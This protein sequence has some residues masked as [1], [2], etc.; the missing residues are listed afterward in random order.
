MRRVETCENK[1][2]AVTRAVFL[3]AVEGPHLQDTGWRAGTWLPWHASSAARV[4]LAYL[5]P[6]RRQEI[7]AGLGMER[8]TDRTTTDRDQLQAKIE[9]AR[10]RGFDVQRSEITVGLGT[11]SAPVFGSDGVVAG[12]ISFAFPEDTVGEGD[13]PRLVEIL[14]GAARLISLRMGNIVYRAGIAAAG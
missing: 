7:L 9:A 13:L 10:D 2:T 1:S 5:D 3:M 14:H 12:A 6:A 11:I 4:M 8:L